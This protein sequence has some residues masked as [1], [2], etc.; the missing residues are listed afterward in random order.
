MQIKTK[1]TKI[2]NTKNLRNIKN[3]IIS[4]KQI[5]KHQIL[6]YPK[7]HLQFLTLNLYIIH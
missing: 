6:F 2:K 7:I 3:T 1:N 4:Q 5:I